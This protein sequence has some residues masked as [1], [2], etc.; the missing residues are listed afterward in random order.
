MIAQVTGS[1]T[2]K[3]L[4]KVEIMTSGGV[5]YELSIPL[6]VYEKLPRIGELGPATANDLIATKQVCFGNP[7]FRDLGSFNLVRD[8]DGASLL[9]GHGN[10]S[11]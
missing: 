8:A 5:G 4:D 1:L 2:A 3:D 7:G 6:G 11:C 9:R 10:A